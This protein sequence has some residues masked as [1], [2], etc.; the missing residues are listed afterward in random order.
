MSK[1]KSVTTLRGG[2]VVE[3]HIVDSRETSKDSISENKEE[4]IEPLT[5]EEITNSPP[6]PPFPQALIKPKKSNHS[7]EIYEVFKQVKVNIPLLDVIKQIPSYAKF[8]KDLC[9]VKRKHKMQKRDFLVE[10]V[11]IGDD[12]QSNFEDT[13]QPEEPNEEEAPELELKPLLEELKYV[14]LREQ[15]TYSVVISSQLMHDQK[16]E[17]PCDWSSQDKKKFLTEVRSFYW[18]DPYLFKYCSDQI[19]RR[20]IPDDEPPELVSHVKDLERQLK[21]IEDG[22]FSDRF[23][24]YMPGFGKSTFVKKR[25]AKR[26]GSECSH[27]VRLACKTPRCKTLEMVSVNRKEKIKFVKDGMSKES[28]DDI[29]RSL[30]M[31]LSGYVQREIQNLWKLLQKESAQFSLG[32]LT[33]KDFVCQFIRKLDGKSILDP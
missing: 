28:L 20:C 25:R 31:H 30:E 32:N 9:T 18:D 21:E 13:I 6:I 23:I 27:C 3:K 8:L 4:S 29:L 19:F 26:L 10:Q 5:H 15:Q 24:S 22:E 12:D 16:G 2:K 17:M 11:P 33:L 7:P 14:Y 1:V